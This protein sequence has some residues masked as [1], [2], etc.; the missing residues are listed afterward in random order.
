V[1]TIGINGER[2]VGL[3]ERQVGPL[4]A[5]RKISGNANIRIAVDDDM[6]GTPVPAAALS[7]DGQP[8]L[9]RSGSGAEQTEQADAQIN[10]TGSNA[11]A[12]NSTVTWKG[13]RLSPL[14]AS[15][16]QAPASSKA[17][18]MA[19]FC[20]PTRTTPSPL[21]TNSTMCAARLS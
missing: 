2:S 8:G 7:H 1:H 17:A 3:P 18:F 21:P 9:V 20:K 14:T 19:T 11:L 15:D 12:P 4:A 6:T 16:W 10:F 13:T 5:L